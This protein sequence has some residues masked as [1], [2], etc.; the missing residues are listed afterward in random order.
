MSPPTS[1]TPD[2]EALLADPFGGDSFGSGL[3]GAP[4]DQLAKP[5][6][7][8]LGAPPADAAVAESPAFGGSLG[9][10]T[11]FG[12][13]TVFGEPTPTF[14][15]LTAFSVPPLA[16]PADDINA[17]LDDPFGSPTVGRSATTS[18]ADL[19]TPSAVPSAVPSAMP[20]AAE[21]FLASALP[22]GGSFAEAARLAAE[23]RRQKVAVEAP[24]AP[25]FDAT[26]LLADPFA[27]SDGDAV[28]AGPFGFGGAP[29]APPS[30]AAASVESLMADPFGF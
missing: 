12:A 24:A 26:A 10:P 14:G 28:L 7:M 2:A 4:V 30:A 6:A 23:Q 5:L 9:A 16:P 8:A 17:L 3:G 15:E 18:S 1:L 11:A 25:T 20:S 29:T 13:P 21:T 19:T 22:D 27:S